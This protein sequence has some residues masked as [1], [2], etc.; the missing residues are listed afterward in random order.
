MKRFVRGRPYR[1]PCKVILIICE[2]DSEEIYFNNFNKRE[3]NCIRIRTPNSSYTDPVNL[4][5]FAKR[6]KQNLNP[7]TTWCVFDIESKSQEVIDKTVRNAGKGINVITSNPCFELWFLLH[8]Q[9]VSSNLNVTDTIQMLKNHISDY[10]KGN[11]IFKLIEDKTQ[12]ALSN[13]RRLNGNHISH[14]LNRYD[15][16]CNPSTQIYQIIEHIFDILHRS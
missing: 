13:S 14:R 10:K 12:V 9:H 8:F 3:W 6:Q 16:R 5:E 1:E 7:E 11:D 4:V 15:I 2:G